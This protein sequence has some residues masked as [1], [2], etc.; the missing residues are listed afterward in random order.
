ME[1]QQKLLASIVANQQ[2]QPKEMLEQFQ[3]TMHDMMAIMFKQTM[4]M[5]KTL[6]PNRI[7][8][9]P[10]HHSKVDTPS[11]PFQQHRQQST[12]LLPKTQGQFGKQAQTL[13][14]RLRSFW[15][16]GG[17][18]SG[19]GSGR[20][21]RLSTSGSIL[22]ISQS[23][24]TPSP[25][26]DKENYWEQTFHPDYEGDSHLFT[27]E[28][29]PVNS[30]DP[31]R[32]YP[33]TVAPPGI[34]KHI[35]KVHELTTASTPPESSP[36]SISPINCHTDQE[37]IILTSTAFLNDTIVNATLSMIQMEYPTMAYQNTYFMEFLTNTSYGN[38]TKVRRLNALFHHPL[39]IWCIPVNHGYN[40]WLYLTMDTTRKEI[41]QHDSLTTHTS[42]NYTSH[43]CHTLAKANQGNWTSEQ[44]S[45]PRQHNSFDCGIYVL[46]HIHKQ[47]SGNSRGPTG[48]PS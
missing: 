15:N 18:G 9:P 30:T 48:N 10:D 4:E 45:T 41:G 28:D 11:I 35:H 27:Q 33:S 20:A 25:D 47:V 21:G 12:N 22:K 3:K 5:V 14:Q 7:P 34:I 32:G 31:S 40:H 23:P 36:D 19:R 43:L 39:N 13:H 37:H 6:L 24:T 16:P 38:A 26:S 46:A 2:Q 8:T 44:V 17:R 29:T 1:S 42:H